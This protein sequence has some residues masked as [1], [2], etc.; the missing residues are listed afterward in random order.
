[1]VV[2][3]RLIKGM[4]SLSFDSLLSEHERDYRA[5]R[6][7]WVTVT[8]SLLY[9]AGLLHL[10]KHILGNLLVYREKMED[11]AR[12]TSEL[13]ATEALMFSLGESMGKN[14]AHFL[15]YNLSMAS[16]DQNRPL[17][18][19]LA[20]D[21]DICRHFSRSELQEMIEPGRHLGQATSLTAQILQEAD[22]RL[23]QYFGNAAPIPSCPL[24][25]E[26][27]HCPLPLEDH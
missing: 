19:V 10:M 2:L 5:V 13:L 26:T 11:N 14:R 8:D 21:P 7:E 17:L 23:R 18:D 16:R 15:L 12:R 25:D 22:A 6:L 27:G 4:A 1:M 3:N 20:D 9:F 24:A